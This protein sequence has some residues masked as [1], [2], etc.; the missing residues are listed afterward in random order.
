MLICI[1]FCNINDIL[2]VCT[3]THIWRGIKI[4]YHA[5]TV[6]GDCYETIPYMTN[7]FPSNNSVG[8]GGLVAKLCP[9]CNP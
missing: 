8:G 2:C 7:L 6:P 4:F 9:T 5:V 3:H 1:Y